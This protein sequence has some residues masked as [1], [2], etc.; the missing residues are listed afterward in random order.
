MSLHLGLGFAGWFFGS[1]ND[2]WGWTTQDEFFTPWLS[3][4]SWGDWNGWGLAG[5]FS[6]FPGGLSVLLDLLSEWL[7]G[8]RESI[9]RG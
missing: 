7:R 1:M 5:A 3:P 4:L 8:P 2:F 9:P 6:L